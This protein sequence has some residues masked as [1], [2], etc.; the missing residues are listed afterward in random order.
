MA[1]RVVEFDDR[2][3]SVFLAAERRAPSDRWKLVLSFREQ[4]S[5]GQPFWTEYPLSSTS[6]AS[7]LLQA[8]Q[9][10]NERLAAVLAD[11]IR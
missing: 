10:P 6:R 2:R 4:Q 11:L 5:A 8:E 7:L 9:I 1:W 3:W